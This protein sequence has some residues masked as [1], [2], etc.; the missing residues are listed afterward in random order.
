[1]AYTVNKYEVRVLFQYQDNIPSQQQSFFV[2]VQNAHY[3]SDVYYTADAEL[4]A[5]LTHGGFITNR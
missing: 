3:S 2:S 1:V 5:I 4:P